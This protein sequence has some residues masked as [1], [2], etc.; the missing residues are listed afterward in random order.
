MRSADLMQ[1]APQWVGSLHY[2]AD[3]AMESTPQSHKVSILFSG[4]TFALR[5][6]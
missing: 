2:G 1:V 3:L 4:M 6:K 5:S